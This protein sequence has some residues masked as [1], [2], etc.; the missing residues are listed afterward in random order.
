M[1]RRLPLTLGTLGAV[2]FCFVTS[3]AHADDEELE[4]V[5]TLANA[6]LTLMSDF[7]GT[8]PNADA[9]QNFDLVRDCLG[10]ASDSGVQTCRDAEIAGSG[11]VCPAITPTPQTDVACDANV[12]KQSSRTLRALTQTVLDWDSDFTVQI[13]AEDSR[14]SIGRHTHTFTGANQ[15]CDG[16]FVAQHDLFRLVV[17]VYQETEGTIT[18]PADPRAPLANVQ[19]SARD[20]SGAVINGPLRAVCLKEDHPIPRSCNAEAAEREHEHEEPAP[21]NDG[22]VREPTEQ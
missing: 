13:K 14:T 11:L 17:V 12:W 7:L 2:A 1:N 4:Q 3:P 10:Y 22:D 16:D 20:A 15:A 8:A 18:I 19:A 6:T 9:Q 5:R 21:E